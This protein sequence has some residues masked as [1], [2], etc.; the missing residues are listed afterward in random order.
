MKAAC[1]PCASVMAL[2]QRCALSIVPSLSLSMVLLCALITP[3]RAMY[4]TPLGSGGLVIGSYQ[5]LQATAIDAQTS[6]AIEC[7]PA[8]PGEPLRLTVRLLNVGS[9]VLQLPNLQAGSPGAGPLRVQLYRD[10]ART[11][12][13]D[14][15]AT[16][17][18][19]DSPVIPTRYSVSLY[20]RVPPRQDVGVGQY[21]LPLTVIIEY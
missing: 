18:F 11:L 2:M 10:A 3:A 16:I 21:Q 12:P 17:S 4:C 9:G 1:R 19:S 15:Q 7:F 6:F 13:L 5:P 20:A 14:E 8:S